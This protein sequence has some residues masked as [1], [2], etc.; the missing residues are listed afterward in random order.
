MGGVDYADQLRSLYN[1][2]C[3]SPKW[4]QRIF[5]AFIDIVFINAYVIYCNLNE[6][7]PVL[8]FRR[9][10]AQ[11]LMAKKDIASEGRKC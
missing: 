7:I 2:D 10:V 11:G 6:K 8:Q 9:Q 3:K 4:W 5:W 1:V